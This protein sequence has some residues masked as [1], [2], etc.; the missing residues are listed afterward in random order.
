MLQLPILSGMSDFRQFKIFC[1][2]SVSKHTMIHLHKFQR[3]KWR[4]LASER[5]IKVDKCRR[6]KPVCGRSLWFK[7]I[8]I[9]PWWF[10]SRFSFFAIFSCSYFFS[11]I[12]QRSKRLL[13]LLSVFVRIILLLNFAFIRG[14]S[15]CKIR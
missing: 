4:S 11:T 2:V 12:F 14:Y 7:L 6:F 5:K 15:K 13:A 9:Y 10:C 1:S 3:K 8:W